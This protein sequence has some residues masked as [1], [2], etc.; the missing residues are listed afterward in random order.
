MVEL[1]F[2]DNLL[3]TPTHEWVRVEGIRAFI[4]ITDYAQSELG[5][6]TYLELP[7]V[8]DTVEIGKP[9]GIIESVKADEE[10]YAPVSGTVIAINEVVMQNPEIV[11]KDP[12]GDGWFIAIEISDLVELKGLMSAEAYRRMLEREGRL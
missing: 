3:Y 11:N 1:Y 9:F 2:P 7:K 10:L 4:G 8:G 6:V 12:Y 5:D